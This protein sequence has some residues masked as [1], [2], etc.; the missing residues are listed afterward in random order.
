MDVVEPPVST[1]LILICDKCGK[2]MKA[3]FDENPSRELVA[4]LGTY[5]SS[6]R[7]NRW[8]GQ[9]RTIFHRKGVRHQ[10]HQRDDCER[11][12]PYA[13]TAAQGERVAPRRPRKPR[14]PSRAPQLQHNPSR[15]ESE[16]GSP[17][18]GDPPGAPPQY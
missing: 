3:D 2:R 1:G 10:G 14:P 5:L 8:S 6:H 4:R 16:G 11:S 7:T 12:A 18:A 13:I 9:W 17:D 15:S